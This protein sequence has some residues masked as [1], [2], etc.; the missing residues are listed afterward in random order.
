[1]KPTAFLAKVSRPLLFLLSLSLAT[2][3]E[4]AG[5]PTSAKIPPPSQS[6][7]DY[8]PKTPSY[9]DADYQL[10]IPLIKAGSYR[11][12]LPFLENALRNPSPHV[13]AKADYLLCLIW[14]ESYAKAVGYYLANEKELGE[15]SYAA[16]HTAR[17][18]YETS[19]FLMAQSLYERRFAKTR[20]T[21]KP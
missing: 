3:A 1:M 18:F 2:Q 14:T 10:A 4:P 7:K 8:A 17:A 9:S 21:S 11:E 16:R 5:K 6:S 13:Y 20:P 12:A 19:D 15:V